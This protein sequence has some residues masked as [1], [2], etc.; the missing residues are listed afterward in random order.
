MLAAPGAARAAPTSE[1]AGILDIRPGQTG[2]VVQV[3]RPVGKVQ[4]GDRLVDAV[5][6]GAFLAKGSRVVVL[7]NEGNRVVVEAKGER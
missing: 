6:N 2:E 3:C 1:Q 7:R 4:V 5:A